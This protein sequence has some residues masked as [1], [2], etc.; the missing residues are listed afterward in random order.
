ML[1]QT[2]GIK[3]YG[4][5]KQ[6]FFALQEFFTQTVVISASAG[7]ACATNIDA[8]PSHPINRSDL[9]PCYSNYNTALMRILLPRLAGYAENTNWMT[10]QPTLALQT[11]DGAEPRLQ[12]GRRTT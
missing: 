7:T 12:T 4:N 10:R 11:V 5:V 8:H 1:S 2:S 6:D 3:D 9:S